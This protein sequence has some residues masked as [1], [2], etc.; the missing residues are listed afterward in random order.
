[1]K[2][3]IDFVKRCRPFK[4]HERFVSDIESCRN[5]VEK[6][7][8][9]FIQGSLEGTLV[10]LPVCLLIWAACRKFKCE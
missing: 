4:S 9:S 7:V 8:T 5:D 2:E 3:V 6:F 10:T 1:M